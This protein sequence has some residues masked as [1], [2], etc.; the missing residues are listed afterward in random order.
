M[1]KPVAGLLCLIVTGGLSCERAARKSASSPDGSRAQRRATPKRP[2]R[3]GEP[4]SA[5]DVAFAVRLRIGLPAPPKTGFRA[6]DDDDPPPKPRPLLA[7]AAQSCKVSQLGLEPCK[8]KTRERWG[9]SAEGPFLAVAVAPRRSLEDIIHRAAELAAAKAPPATGHAEQA[10]GWP[11]TF[12][13][14]R[15]YFPL[16]S[17]ATFEKAF[18]RSPVC[19]QARKGLIDWLMDEE[20]KPLAKE[21]RARLEESRGGCAS[22]AELKGAAHSPLQPLAALGP[23]GVVLEPL[24]QACSVVGADKRRLRCDEVGP[25]VGV[26]Q[27]GE[28]Q[29][30]VFP[31]PQA[32]RGPRKVAAPADLRAR[33]RRITTVRAKLAAAFLRR[34]ASLAPP[35]GWLA[36]TGT[37]KLPDLELRVNAA[38]LARFDAS[39]GLIQVFQVLGG[40]APAEVHK[41]FGIGVD[42]SLRSWRFQAAST[43]LLRDFRLTLQTRGTGRGLRLRWKLTPLGLRV[44]GPAMR[45]LL[46]KNLIQGSTL[47]RALEG[48]A[49]PALTKAAPSRGI[50]AQATEAKELVRFLSPYGSLLIAARLWPDLLRTPAGLAWLTK[51]APSLKR[52]GYRELRVTLRGDRLEALAVPTPQ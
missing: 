28:L 17:Q 31:P 50:L 2:A 29:R 36:P 42:T 47:I 37:A 12:A 14:V 27:Y 34:A 43:D 4:L 23:L 44:L 3:A 30:L 16:A 38:A 13:M 40:G 32:R 33:V 39:Y 15:L 25:V 8:A 21:V 19:R 9:L 52:S 10:R 26:P 5:S 18:A 24:V 11:P 20:K 7:L 35:A 6:P 41:R 48:S 49:L 1:S 45:S 22:A 46:G 51:L